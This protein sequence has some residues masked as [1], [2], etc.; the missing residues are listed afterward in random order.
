MGEGLSEK[1]TCCTPLV[2]DIVIND[3]WIKNEIKLNNNNEED[4]MHSLYNKV[5]WKKGDTIKRNGPRI[6][7]DGVIGLRRRYGDVIMYSGDGIFEYQF[8]EEKK[9]E[10]YSDHAPIAAVLTPKAESVGGK[11]RTRKKRKRKRK[12]T[13][14]RRRKK[15]TKKKKKRRRRKKTKKRR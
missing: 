6:E 5:T 3:E 1:H 9:D 10:P 15:S 12:K 4:N 8:P 13:K 14:K 11:K 2:I 7:Q